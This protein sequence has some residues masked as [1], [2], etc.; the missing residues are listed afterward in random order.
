MTPSLPTLSIAWRSLADLSSWL[1][2][3]VPT[4]AILEL[5]LTG[6]LIRSSFDDGGDG[7]VDAALDPWLL[8]PA[9]TFFRP[10]VKMASA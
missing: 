10:S 9:V 2:A 1:A 3:Q 4:W 8:A 5:L 7:L 6:M